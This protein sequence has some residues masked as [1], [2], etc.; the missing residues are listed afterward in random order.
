MDFRSDNTASIYPQIL[1]DLQNINS[2]NCS[3]YGNDPKSEELRKKLSQLFDRPCWIALTSTGTA[4]NCVS[5]KTLT[6]T[7]GCIISSDDAHIHHDEGQAPELLLSGAKIRTFSTAQNKIDLDAARIWIEK[8]N[9]LKPHAGLASTVSVTYASEWGDLYSLQE[10]RDIRSFCDQYQLKLHVDGARFSNALVAQNLSLKEFH[11]I[12]KPDAISFG[13]T[14][15]GGFMAECVVVFNQTHAE[16]LA[17]HHKQS[18]QLLSKTR[19]IATQFLTLLNNDQ[20][21]SLAKH[22]NDMAV[23]LA[24]IFTEFSAIELAIPVKTNQVFVKMDSSL[25]QKLTNQNVLFY[26]WKED[27]YRFVCSWHTENKELEDFKK[28]LSALH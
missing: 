2:D 20:W 27:I 28:V 18:A 6:P 17:Y 1:I 23:Q 3:S 7:Y 5:L 13:L 9:G 24:N 19:F 15:N 22:A 21:L 16:A 25:A 10:L 4:A 8:S 12:L 11:N 26:K 14:K